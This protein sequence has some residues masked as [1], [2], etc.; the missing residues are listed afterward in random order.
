LAVSILV[1]GY[2]V[3]LA[4]SP[5]LEIASSPGQTCTVIVEG[6][7][8]PVVLHTNSFPHHAVVIVLK[9]GLKFLGHLP[10]VLPR[11]KCGD[12]VF[13]RAGEN[14]WMVQVADIQLLESAGNY[15][16]I[17]FSRGLRIKLRSGPEVE[18]SRRRSQQFRD[19]TSL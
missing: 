17:H 16:Q 4:I 11:R 15:T 10:T 14:C 19:F 9:S 6:L 18:V 8:Q 1:C 13:V 5:A 7:Y 2:I 12:Q 3:E